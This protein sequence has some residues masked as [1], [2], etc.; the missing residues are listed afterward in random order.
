MP[1]PNLLPRQLGFLDKGYEIKGWFSKGSF[2]ICSPGYDLP[3]PTIDQQGV[4]D[5]FET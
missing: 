1:W 2:S 5:H 4:I 3:I